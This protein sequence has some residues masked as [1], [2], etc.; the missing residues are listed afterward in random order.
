MPVPRARA[1]AV[2]TATE[3]WFEENQRPLPWRSGYDPYHVWVSEVMLQQTRMEVVVGYFERFIR[4]FPSLDAL[5]CASVEEVL[6]A[7]SGLGYYR[8]ARLLHAGASYVLEQWQGRIPDSVPELLKIPGVGRYT[9]GAIASIAFDRPAPIVDGNVARVLARLEMIAHPTGSASFSREAWEC[10]SSLAGAA[11]SPRMLNQ[12]LMELGAL[13][14]TPRNPSCGICPA[15]GL[16]A[17]RAAG[18][19]EQFPRSPVR[20]PSVDLR[21]PLFVVTDDRGFILLRL[22]EGRLMNGL[23]H[24]PHGNADLLGYC[25]DFDLGTP[26]GTFA[27]TVTHRRITFE[28]FAA[29]TGGSIADSRGEYVWVDPARLADVPHPSYVR[30]AV[31]LA[32]SARDERNICTSR[33]SW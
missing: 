27:H 24:L 19:V 16:C 11:A 10:A 17:A 4:R 18:V 7:W 20:R 26:L 8:R 9:A 15:A 25:D 22:G 21:I 1:L 30:K 23:Y 12:S 32:M 29:D 14:C 28:L 5:A 2:S 3:R 13:V 33:R 31:R 6:A